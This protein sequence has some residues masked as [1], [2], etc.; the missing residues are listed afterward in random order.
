MESLNRWA[1]GRAFLFVYSQ[2]PP[3]WNDPRFPRSS[4]SPHLRRLK[5]SL[6]IFLPHPLSS[7]FGAHFRFVFVVFYP[8]WNA[9]SCFY[10]RPFP[11]G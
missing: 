11:L 4:T 5:T 8:L 3:G 10:L 6:R 7:R 9:Q 2:L 1:A